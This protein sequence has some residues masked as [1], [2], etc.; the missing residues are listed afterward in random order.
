MRIASRQ[1]TATRE[2]INRDNTAPVVLPSRVSVVP[3]IDSSLG[4]HYAEQADQRVL[5]VQRSFDGSCSGC[6]KAC[7]S[8]ERSADG[9]QADLDVSAPD[10]PLEVEADS[11]ADQVVQRA[12]GQDEATEPASGA[13]SIQEQIQ[14]RLAEKGIGREASGLAHAG[15][16][17]IDVE[18]DRTRG[19]G[20]PLPSKFKRQMENAFAAHFDNVRVHTDER[21]AAL[22]R[23]LRAHAFTQGNDIYFDNGEFDP[24]SQQGTHLLA[25]ELTHTLQQRDDHVQPLPW[26]SMTWNGV[27]NGTLPTLVQRQNVVQIPPVVIA[28]DPPNLVQI[29]P[30]VIASDPK[31]EKKLQQLSDD[32]VKRLPEVG[33][34]F[35]NEWYS[36]TNGALAAST[37]P[38]IADALPYWWIALAGNLAWAATSLF[39]SSKAAVVAVSFIGAAVGSGSVEKSTTPAGP[40]SGKADV[41]RLL[42]RA[43]DKLEAALQSQ[44]FEAASDIVDQNAEHTEEQDR[45]LFSKLFAEVPY[46]RRFE[47]IYNSTLSAI[48]SNLANFAAQYQAWRDQIQHC[49][50]DKAKNRPIFSGP[51]VQA[52]HDPGQPNDASHAGPSRATVQRQLFPPLPIFVRSPVDADFKACEIEH[53]FQPKLSVPG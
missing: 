1:A 9:V 27:S 23:Q 14:H 35:V 21:A 49:A 43:R 8:E 32:A 5:C 4:N 30:V 16:R 6:C 28:A 18:L 44:V 41:G 3:E 11:I 37:E 17:G 2:S 52:C 38:N 33:K 15:A 51:T 10:D 25:H 26:R 13:N 24:D 45:T 48:N 36:A 46:D 34:R 47:A 7:Q 29:P 50:E 19:S 40:P 31:K 39:P 20:S 12:R 42:A 22:S 53:P